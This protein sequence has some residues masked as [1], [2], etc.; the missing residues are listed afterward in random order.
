[1]YP[2]WQERYSSTSNGRKDRSVKYYLSAVAYMLKM[3]GM[4][5]RRPTRTLVDTGS[6]VTCTL[7]HERVWNDIACGK[8]FKASQCPVMA[9]NGESLSL[10][11][12][13]NVDLMMGKH[14]RCHTVLIVQGITME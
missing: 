8:K 13:T 3:Q 5:E 1:M 10:C 11:G 9:V 12:Q 6:S 2:Q 14:V 7:L 4:V